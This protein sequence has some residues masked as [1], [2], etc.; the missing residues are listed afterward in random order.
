MYFCKLGLVSVLEEVG[1]SNLF[2]TLVL[3]LFQHR[4]NNLSKQNGCEFVNLY[5]SWAKI[6]PKIIYEGSRI[7]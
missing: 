6:I 7:V 5:T 2:C 1:G 4:V 3:T